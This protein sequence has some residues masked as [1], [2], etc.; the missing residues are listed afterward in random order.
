[1]N[2]EPY[3][4]FLDCLK[5]N[6]D[7]FWYRNEGID[8]ESNRLYCWGFHP[9]SFI[10]ERIEGQGYFES[11]QEVVADIIRHLKVVK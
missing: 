9:D 4:N 3:K 8:E 7:G 11:Y 5:E 6:M 10:L 1:M 2:E